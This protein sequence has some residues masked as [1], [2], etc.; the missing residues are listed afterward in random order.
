[1]RIKD[2]AEVIVGDYPFAN[3]LYDEL[4][5]ILE[6]HPDKQDRK[7][8]VMATMT[9]WDWNSENV[10]IK[11][12]KNNIIESARSLGLLTKDEHQH[13]Y[14]D[15]YDQLRYYVEDLWGNI[16]RKGDYT[17]VHSHRP[18]VFSCVYFLKTKWYHSPLVFTDSE[19]KLRHKKISPKEGTFVIFPSH[20]FH[21]VPEHRYRETR[22]T[23]SGNMRINQGV[24]SN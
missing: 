9:E 12:L 11:R 2:Y 3:Q 19:K 18:S 21:L 6:K 10:R 1:M 13:Q 24:F 5:P 17:E 14:G 16:Y 4:V 23:L 20:L 22:I 7:T 15:K 8:N